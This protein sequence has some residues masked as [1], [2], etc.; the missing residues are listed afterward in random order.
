MGNYDKDY[1]ELVVYLAAHAPGGHGIWLRALRS[2]AKLE[3]KE[4]RRDKTIKDVLGYAYRAH[5]NPKSSKHQPDFTYAD[6]RPAL[7]LTWLLLDR[8]AAEELRG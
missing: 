3:I 1:D 7:A 2:V 6:T 8:I 4:L 5:K